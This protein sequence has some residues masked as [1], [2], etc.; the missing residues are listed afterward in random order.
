MKAHLFEPEDL[1][2]LIPQEAQVRD[3]APAQ[4]LD[5]GWKFKDGGSAFTIWD[6]T[7]EGLAPIFCGGALR[8]HE[9]YAQ[10]W[11]LFSR[12]KPKVP[13]RL[14]RIVRRFVAEQRE[15][16]V[17]AQVAASNSGACG[18][19]RLIG[20]EQEARLCGAAPD[21]GDLLVFVR[22]GLLA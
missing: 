12:H 10:L 19:A 14:T 21:G 17:D 22:K 6:D 16:R 4:R 1:L 3:L 5:F 2:R 8:M 13:V 7:P 20:L 15:R 9:H 18:W 11:A